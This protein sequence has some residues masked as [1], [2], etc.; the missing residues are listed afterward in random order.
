MNFFHI[1]YYFCTIAIKNGPAIMQRN[2]TNHCE[3]TTN[4]NVKNSSSFFQKFIHT[5]NRV[6]A[7]GTSKVNLPIFPCNLL[8]NNYYYIAFMSHTWQVNKWFW[9]KG[10]L[11]CNETCTFWKALKFCTCLTSYVTDF[12][13]LR[14]QVQLHSMRILQVWKKLDSLCIMIPWNYM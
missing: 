2:W 13:A 7:S 4:G 5:I 8:I 10:L 6:P 3:R 14:F 11:S 9:N 1:S 12:D